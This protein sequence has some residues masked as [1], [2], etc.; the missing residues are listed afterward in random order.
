MT[1]GSTITHYRKKLGLTQEAL[2]QEFGVTNQA[3][4]KWELEQAC[5]DILLLPRLADF[6]GISMDALFGREAGET[7][8]VCTDVSWPDDDV[9]RVVVY[10]GK[11]LIC[12]GAAAKDFNLEYRKDVKEIL[13]A[14]SVTCGDVKGN[15]CS[16]LC[17]NCAEVGGDVDAGTAVN[18]ADVGGSVDA[19]T[20]VT[21]GNVGGG[22]D[23]GT[24][25]ICGNVEGNVDAGTSVRCG[26]VSG[27][28]DAGG[29]V[30]IG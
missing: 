28:I 13:S 27:D 1:L 29:K 3:V 24:N 6:F 17:V 19:G 18:C 2:A 4:S 7:E 9:L 22:V 5:P 8:P 14:V 16:N 30:Q 12:G 26:N 15:V 10:E 21:C 20:N 23:A 11:R 25:V